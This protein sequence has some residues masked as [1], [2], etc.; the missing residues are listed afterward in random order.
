MQES[1]PDPIKLVPKISMYKFDTA[2]VEE[3]YVL[4]IGTKRFEISEGVYQIIELI[5]GK[6]TLSEI[7]SAY[8]SIRNKT[9]SAKDIAAIIHSFLKPYGILENTTSD[10]D[11]QTS[12]SYFYFQYPFMRANAVHAVS[13]ILKTLFYPKIL[14]SFIFFSFVFFGYFYFFQLQVIDFT[15]YDISFQD[16]ILTL[17]IFG[18]LGIF[19]ELGHAS[20]CAYYGASPGEIGI[21]LYLRFPVLY[22]NVTDAWRLP[23][24]QRA[25]V[26][27]GGIY[28]QLIFIPILFILYLTTASS[29]F[30]FLILFNYGS[31][32]FNLNPIFRF[33]G[34]W[35]FSDIAG[36]PNLRKRSLE[37][38]KYFVKRFILREREIAEPIFLRISGK[39]KSFLCVYGIVSASFFVLFFY[40]IFFLF[41]DL[42]SN[43][44]GLVYKTFSEIISG[45]AAGDWKNIGSALSRFFFPSLLILMLSF[46]IY[47]MM[48]RLMRSTKT[49]VRWGLLVIRKPRTPGIH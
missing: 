26:D 45:F 14:I 16:T 25:M 12:N 18:V 20:A 42:I 3:S 32:L 11:A 6:K 1:L 2:L 35:L 27:F 5:D 8:S 37:I 40:K 29:V 44:P 10:V 24:M 13:N 21:G 22:S 34:Y 15:I 49:I 46:A 43:Y 48:K 39:I 41:P 31:A 28:F 38:L 4:C 19:H 47:R 17:I 7:A 9:Y 36:V 33:D 23:R 30:L